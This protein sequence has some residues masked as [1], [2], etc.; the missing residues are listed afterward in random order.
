MK[1]MRKQP[2]KLYLL[3]G[4]L[5]AGKTTLLNNLLELLRGERVGIIINEF[6]AAGVDG[7]VVE[8]HGLEMIELNNGQI[9][10]S[11]LAGDFVKAIA[12]FSEMPIDY[13][14]VE[15]S[16]LANPTSLD[17]VLSEVKNLTGDAYDY[18][19]M[20]C[21]ADTLQV[22]DLVQAVNAVREQI[23]R[24][25]I[26]LINKID[27]V[28]QEVVEEIEEKI[29]EL[30]PHA[31]I[32]R[33]TYCR[34]DQDI[35]KSVPA[36]PRGP[37][38]GQVVSSF[39]RPVTF[40]IEAHEAVEPEGIRKFVSAVEGDTLRIKGFFIAPDGWRY[41][42]VVDGITRITS[43][44]E[45]KVGQGI[46]IISRIGERLWEKIPPAWGESTG[47]KFTLTQKQLFFPPTNIK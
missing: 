27:L 30:Q 28:E 3:T 21:V 47:I 2:I 31:R 22:L 6:G 17:T 32:Y 18:R 11:C 9:F 4:F 37:H 26:I 29:R 25:E 42:D 15:S 19:G 43:V 5:G 35:F 16:G 38:P 41:L 10:C 45:P 8:H 44:S 39:S 40:L 1:Q 14:L 46:V 33:T 34:V 20:I 23:I 12:E 36:E 24:S 13:L 7:A